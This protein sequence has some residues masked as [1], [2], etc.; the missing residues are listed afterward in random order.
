[1]SSST[2]SRVS[3]I[4]EDEWYSRSEELFEIKHLESIN[5]ESGKEVEEDVVYVAL[6]G[7][8]SHDMDALV[9]TLNHLL[10]PFSSSLVNLIH[11]FPQLHY[12]P[13]PLGKLPISQVN[14]EQ[15]ERYMIQERGKRREFLQKFLDICSVSKVKVET[16]LI[17]SDM[18][19]KALLD[20]IPVLYVKK[21]VLGAPKSSLRKL[22]SG[23]GNETVDQVVQNVPEFCELHI[24]CEG[25]QVVLE[26]LTLESPSSGVIHNIN[27]VDNK[28]NNNDVSENFMEDQMQNN[29]SFACSCFTPKARA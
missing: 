18:E 5:E 8:G 26:K 29:A 19:A 14:P 6:L 16:I 27:T 2:S 15:K 4:E 7:T 1:M 3:E 20:L 28:N 11:V 17:E 25:K 24:I 23:K 12:I 13:T 21:L 22:R 9:W 10:H